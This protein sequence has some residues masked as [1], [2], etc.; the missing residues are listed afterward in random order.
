MPM[1]TAHDIARRVGVNQCTVSRALT[2]FPHVSAKT[3][4]KVRQACRALGYVPNAMASALSSRRTHAIAIHIPFRKETVLADP[5]LPEFLSGVNRECAC[6]DYTIILSFVAPDEP[7]FAFSHLIK[8]RRADGLILVGLQT[9]D[10][11]IAELRAQAIPCVIGHV[12]GRLGKWIAS[13]DVDNHDIGRRAA[14][15]LI[16]RGHRRIG[17]VLEPEGNLSGND[18]WRGVSE[19]LRHHR[20]GA[21]ERLVQRTAIT[22]SAARRATEKLLRRVRPPS[23][24]LVDTALGIFGAL[25]ARRAMGRSV[26]LLGV[27]SPLL[28]DLH[29]DLPRIRAPIAELG[30]AMTRVLIQMIKT[31][32][33]P[34]PHRMLR[35]TILDERG[36]VFQG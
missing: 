12:Q 1:I 36:R 18:F 4:D 33:T 31:G 17:A 15:F 28:Q 25:E 9:G 6:H 8:A 14:E 24:I 29:P 26:D 32:Q 3:A 10:R 19:A 21:D 16:N 22:A 13:V 34:K 5:F 27:D 20:L 7:G 11:R 30:A 35:A 2:G 23:A